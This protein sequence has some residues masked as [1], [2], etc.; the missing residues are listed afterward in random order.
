MLITVSHDDDLGPI[1]TAVPRHSS[2]GGQEPRTAHIATFMRPR[3]C[4]FRGSVQL[5]ER[6][7]PRRHRLASYRLF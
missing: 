1:R 5:G 6:V 4:A 7:L 3:P 2:G